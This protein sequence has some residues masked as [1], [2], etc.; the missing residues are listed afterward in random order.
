MDNNIP[1]PIRIF[2][3]DHLTGEEQRHIS[4]EF[5]T[6]LRPNLQVLWSGMPRNIAQK[7]ADE[8]GMQTLTTAMGPLMEKNKKSKKQWSSYIRGASAIFAL[9]ISKGDIVTVLTPPPPT[10]FHPSGSTSFQTIEEPI[11]KGILGNRSVRRIIVVHP[12][13][14]EASRMQ[15]QLWPE[16]QCFAWVSKFGNVKAVTNWRQV[17]TRSKTNL[18]GSACIPLPGHGNASTEWAQGHHTSHNHDDKVLQQSQK[19]ER[20]LLDESYAWKRQSLQREHRREIKRLQKRQREERK[21]HGKNRRGP[22]LHT[23][24]TEE[25]KQLQRT[26]D[27][28]KASLIKEELLRVKD[29]KSRHKKEKMELNIRRRDRKRCHATQGKGA[30]RFREPSPERPR[31]PVGTSAPKTFSMGPILTACIYLLIISALRKI[32]EL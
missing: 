7:W 17:K 27:Q 32:L 10:R 24:Q 1:D 6:S 29:L 4:D 2:L 5:N 23:K 3:N 31:N 30:S 22:V 12:T 21:R 18:L 28:Q 9:R 25:M 16:D 20:Q 11:I 13:I 15:Y 8:R 19:Q 26:L 14:P